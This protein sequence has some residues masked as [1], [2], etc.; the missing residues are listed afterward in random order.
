M[1]IDAY[2]KLLLTIIRKYNKPFLSLMLFLI[3]IELC[4]AQVSKVDNHN[5]LIAHNN[6]NLQGDDKSLL[7]SQQEFNWE[8]YISKEDQFSALWPEMPITHSLYRRSKMLEDDK[9][10]RMYAAYG[11]GTVYVILALDKRKET[12]NLNTFIDEFKFYSILHKEI[13]FDRDIIV[14]GLQAKQYIIKLRYADG[15]AQFIMSKNKVYIAVVVSR[16]ISHQTIK[17]FL[18]SLSFNQIINGKEITSHHS[19][20]SYTTEK[21]SYV[22][23]PKE[24]N[25]IY[26]PNAVNQKF[27]IVTKPEPGYTERARKNKVKGIV[28][29]KGVL[30]S[31]GKVTN[32]IVAKGLPDGLTDNA[33]DA[34][35]KIKFIPS[36]RDGKYVSTYVHLEYGF[37]VY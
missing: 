34:A 11:D 23:K 6:I 16:N 9:K 17:D 33:L 19:P 20:V 35:S 18:G 3:F 5:L 10:G 29:I 32:V 26:L 14:D 22:P 12:E 15:I 28:I 1:K 4:Y 24:V 31:S 13:S 36:I 7:S 2:M 27:I 8:R 37:T 21:P 30:S 25:G